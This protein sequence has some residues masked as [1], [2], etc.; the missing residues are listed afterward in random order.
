M[1]KY[2]VEL[3]LDMTEDIRKDKISKTY[4]E[5][6]FEYLPFFVKNI[7]KNKKIIKFKTNND[8]TLDTIVSKEKDYEDITIT[9]QI[10]DNI[11]KNSAII[12][13]KIRKYSY[14]TIRSYTE[15]GKG[16]QGIYY[17]VIQ[18]NTKINSDVPFV[19]K[20]GLFSYS[21]VTLSMMEEDDREKILSG[22][23]NLADLNRINSKNSKSGLQPDYDNITVTNIDN[24]ECKTVIYGD[25]AKRKFKTDYIDSSKLYHDI[26]SFDIIPCTLFDYEIQPIVNADSWLNL[27]LPK[28]INIF[29]RMEQFSNSKCQKRVLKK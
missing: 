8:I 1:E 6:I 16:S 29:S 12:N 22:N 14:G 10:S 25:L 4:I 5:T 13:E 18:E 23:I 27:D 19:V 21:Y 2:I 15:F 9:G 3:L 28:E 7:D 20:T 17:T 11:S 26:Y 24:K